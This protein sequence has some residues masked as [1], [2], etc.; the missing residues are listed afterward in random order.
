M[1]HGLIP[2]LVAGGVGARYNSRDAT[3]FWLQAVQEYTKLAEEGAEILLAPVPRMYAH[4]NSEANTT[5]A[6]VG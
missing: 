2:N 6:Q 3:W 4:D 1:R 5:N